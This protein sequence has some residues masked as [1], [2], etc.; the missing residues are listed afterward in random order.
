MEI[1]NTVLPKEHTLVVSGDWHVGNNACNFQMIEDLVER[2]KNDD[3]A[4]LALNGD[5]I[6]AITVDDPRF[7]VSSHVPGSKADEVTPLKQTKRVKELLEPIRE[8]IVV[9]NHGNHEDKLFDTGN[10]TELLCRELG[11]QYGTY[12]SKNHIHHQTGGGSKEL[13]Y[14][15]LLWHGYGSTRSRV[16]DPRQRKRN[17]LRSIRRKLRPL[18]DDCDLMLM[19]HV[20]LLLKDDPEPTTRLYDDGH[21]IVSERSVMPVMETDNGRYVHPDARF[22]GVTGT[23]L[24]TQM[25]GYTTYS[26]KHG[27]PPTDLGWLEIHYDDDAQDRGIELEKVIWDSDSDEEPQMMEDPG[28]DMVLH[29]RDHNNEH[30]NDISLEQW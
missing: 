16:D 11:V 28:I 24:R 6:E 27:Y 20:H 25:E 17:K 21:E 3:E 26:E 5:Q 22:Y 9:I 12:T 4:Y 1:I 14:S 13:S 30:D 15:L 18:A 8:D 7:D 23:S 19:G 29:D 10:F 2:V